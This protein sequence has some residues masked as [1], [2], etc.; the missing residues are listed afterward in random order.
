[1]AENV[2]P[3]TA[4]ERAEAESWGMDEDRYRQAKADMAEAERKYGAEAHYEAAAMQRE[5]EI[6]RR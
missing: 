3:L 2:E 1:M 6:N 5:I 4:E